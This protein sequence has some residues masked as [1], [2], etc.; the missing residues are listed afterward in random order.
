MVRRYAAVQSSVQIANFTLFGRLPAGSLYGAKITQAGA[1][2][3]VG[4][5]ATTPFT[6]EWVL[7]GR[8][9]Q[10]SVCDLQACMHI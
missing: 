7:L 2:G 4:D 10:V 9:N 8:T 5:A 6:I 1:A 3:S